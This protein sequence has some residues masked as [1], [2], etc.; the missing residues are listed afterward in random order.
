[1]TQ[2]Y[3]QMTK[4]NLHLSSEE[5]LKSIQTTKASA[6]PNSI[7]SMFLAQNNIDSVSQGAAEEY[8]NLMRVVNS[9]T[10]QAPTLPV[11]DRTMNNS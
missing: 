5:R 4:Q 8:S 2:L 10:K 6:K 11:I 7:A 9:P 1:M 3:H